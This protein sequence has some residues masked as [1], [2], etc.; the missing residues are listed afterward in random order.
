[1]NSQSRNLQKNNNIS[2]SLFA[3]LF[4]FC[5]TKGLADDTVELNESIFTKSQFTSSTNH[6]VESSDRLYVRIKEDVSVDLIHRLIPGSDCI[7][8]AD[9]MGF[10]KWRKL[11]D[12]KLSDSQRKLW[13][14]RSKMLSALQNLYVLQLP[15]NYKETEDKKEALQLLEKSGL[16]EYAVFPTRQVLHSDGP[17]PKYDEQMFFDAIGMDP[18]DNT[19]PDASEVLIAIVDSGTDTMHED[20]QENIYINLAEIPNNGKDDDLNGYIDDVSG[21]D[22]VGDITLDNAKTGDLAPD[23]DPRPNHSSNRHGTHVAGCA[24]AALYNSIG[25]ASPGRNAKILPIKVGADNMDEVYGL[26]QGYEGIAYAGWMG[27]DIINCSWG[28]ST[29]SPYEK[30]IITA[31]SESGSIIIASAGND[32]WNNDLGFSYPNC[33]PEVISVGASNNATSPTGFSN[34]GVDVDVFAP[35]SAVYTTLPG[36]FYGPMSGTS[37]SG[38]IVAGLS[39]VALAANPEMT[40][41]ELRARLR[42]GSVPNSGNNELGQFAGIAQVGS[43]VTETAPLT[44]VL[45]KSKDG[46]HVERT[47]DL[48]FYPLYGELTDL[49][50]NLSPA[51]NFIEL[52]DTLFSYLTLNEGVTENVDFQLLE[53]NPWYRATSNLYVKGEYDGGNSLDNFR[54]TFLADSNGAMHEFVGYADDLFDVGWRFMKDFGDDV[55]LTGLDFRNLRGIIFNPVT[56]DYLR[57][58][59]YYVTG[60]H[61]YENGNLLIATGR[62]SKLLSYDADL[63]QIGEIDLSD[64]TDYIQA[65]IVYEESDRIIVIGN[66]SSDNLCIAISD[67]GGLSFSYHPI[68]ESYLDKPETIA[69]RISYAG[70]Y[71]VLADDNGRFF[72]S[73]DRGVTWDVFS[74]PAEAKYVYTV[75]VNKKGDVAFFASDDRRMDRVPELY[76]ISLTSMDFDNPQFQK[77][78]DSEIGNNIFSNILGMM[79][80]SGFDWV[81]NVEN[82]SAPDML[83]LM[84]QEG[85]IIYR[86]NGFG[87]KFEAVRSVRGRE[88]TKGLAVPLYE[89]SDMLTMYMASSFVQSLT[90]PISN[91][92]QKPILSFGNQQAVELDGEL[93]LSIADSIEVDNEL[94]LPLTFINEEE[95]VDAYFQILEY[96]FSTDIRIEDYEESW[97]YP[98]DTA[99]VNV[100]F[101][102]ENIGLQ[103]ETVKVKIGDDIVNVQLSLM[104]LQQS[105][106]EEL[107][108]TISDNKPY[109]IDGTIFLPHRSNAK[110]YGIGGNIIRTL[111]G[112]YDTSELT[113]GVYF[114]SYG[115]NDDLSTY[116]TYK[117]IV[118]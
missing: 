62:D 68:V 3:V 44:L 9:Y 109:I 35:G 6:S 30:D 94:Q 61:Q 65:V 107:E 26:Y 34:Y 4:I 14:R 117:F 102:P 83:L 116:Q 54:F 81:E 100:V 73:M 19:L 114:L 20:L 2:I 10:E 51:E 21:W 115:L 43:L 41:D 64:F 45:D 69:E 59:Q 29:F 91:E 40:K 39:A 70:D 98:G 33:F 8:Y 37:M 101:T 31:V 89:G 47:F 7:E 96:P 108:N 50:V 85:N 11:Q 52:S 78:P 56:Q 28:G 12:N 104:G 74:T 16:V 97:L 95:S 111:S 106:V 18:Y 87:N 76:E 25:V 67:D 24:S 92:Y 27:A 79:L 57:V 32:A 17:D 60:L 90:F 113:R 105:N 88:Y 63:K 23:N 38:P 112:T 110:I 71:I 118:K 103:N 49:K 75:K 86:K 55:W 42:Y 36:D 46:D 99:F 5:A 15:N 72:A 80:P 84:G 22:F 77:T 53:N 1:M 93:Y 66:P 13:E 48:S 58:G 82:P